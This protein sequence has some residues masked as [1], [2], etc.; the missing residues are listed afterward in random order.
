[1]TTAPKLYQ[2]NV[3]WR[4]RQARLAAGI[5]QAELAEELGLDEAVMRSYERGVGRVPPRHLLAMAGLLG[6]SLENLFTRWS[7]EQRPLDVL[8]L[9]RLGKFRRLARFWFASRGRWHGEIGG[10]L[11][12]CRLQRTLLLR[13]RPR[14]DRLVFEELGDGMRTRRPEDRYFLDMLGRDINDLPDREYGAWMADI[15]DRTL[16]LRRPR[17]DYTEALVSPSSSLVYHIRHDRLILPWYSGNDL[18]VMGVS[19]PKELAVAS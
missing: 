2:I 1:V 5:T 12:R 19:M 16:A 6:L 10:V 8:A 18:F 15:Y 13:K 7:S 9:Q 14:V 17:L 11:E 4:L 3:G